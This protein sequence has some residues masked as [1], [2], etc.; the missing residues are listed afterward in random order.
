MVYD[1]PEIPDAKHPSFA[2]DA[3]NCY[4]AHVEIGWYEETQSAPTLAVTPQATTPMDV[5]LSNAAEDDGATSKDGSTIN[6]DSLSFFA[7]GLLLLQCYSKGDSGY[8]VALSKVCNNKKIS[9]WACI[10]SVSLQMSV[11]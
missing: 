2:D 9:C 8:R 10:K 4:D 7:K 6:A 11:C 3:D 5:V 1:S